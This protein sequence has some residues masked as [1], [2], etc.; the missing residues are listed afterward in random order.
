[1][2]AAERRGELPGAGVTA[3]RRDLPDG[4]VGGAQQ[5]R[6]TLHPEAHEVA[7]RCESRGPGESLDEL[8]PAH[9]GDGGQVVE[10]HL[11]GEVIPHVVHSRSHVRAPRPS[12]SV[13]RIPSGAEQASVKQVCRQSLCQR[14]RV[15]GLGSAFQPRAEGSPDA[16][17]RRVVQGQCVREIL[18]QPRAA[19]RF[20]CLQQ[21]LSAQVQV[22]RRE[23]RGGAAPAQTP[24]RTR[25]RDAHGPG[26]QG[27]LRPAAWALAFRGDRAVE[28]DGHQEVRRRDRAEGLRLHR[29]RVRTRQDR[30]PSEPVTRSRQT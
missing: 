27:R 29:I 28:H 12:C 4:V 11:L 20:G 6:R 24:A 22:E 26:P 7:V 15:E 9:P 17:D 23:S 18:H 21:Q 2:V 5:L 8:V 16:E 25:R 1:M 13:S 3:Q 19:Q 10:G 30:P 14:V